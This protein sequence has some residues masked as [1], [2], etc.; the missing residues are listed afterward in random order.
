LAGAAIV[1]LRDSLGIYA[2]KG[3][4]KFRPTGSTSFIS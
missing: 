2:D 3:V 1:A 4:A